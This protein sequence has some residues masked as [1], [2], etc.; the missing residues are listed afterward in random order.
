MGKCTYRR[1]TCKE[2]GYEFPHY[3][4]NPCP[5][6][7]ADRQC[8]K[9]TQPGYK[10]CGLFGH[11][12]P[13]PGRGYYGKAMA[14]ITGT[15]SKF[16]LT[17]LASKYKEMMESG[18]ILSNRNSIEIV[19][20]RIMQL[21]ERIDLNEAPD[22]LE[23][24]QK[25]WNKFNKARFTGSDLEATKLHKELDAEFEAAY[26]DYEAWKQMFEAVDLHRTLLESE[27]KIVKDMKAIMTAEDAYQMVAKIFAIILEV[28]EDP[29]KLKRYQYEMTRL[30][31]DGHVVDAE[32]AED[33]ANGTTE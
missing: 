16:P 32:W 3:N 20:T 25:L 12:G 22:R 17:R 33:E 19:G 18:R 4:I 5:Q 27:V 15:K 24:L 28:E 7:G 8:N 11:G 14:P 10:R 1:K 9:N 26:H 30:V 6:C 23:N 13:S 29:N 31:G 2:C 21:A